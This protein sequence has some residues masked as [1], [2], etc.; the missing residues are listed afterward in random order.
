MN[1]PLSLVM[2]ACENDVRSVQ[3]IARTTWL[4]LGV[5][6]AAVDHLV[7]SGRVQM[8]PM[9]SGCTPGACGACQLLARG[10][11]TSLKPRG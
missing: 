4:S 8:M 10:C 6:G 5:V 9:V 2:E 11:R 3:A 7:R 1:G